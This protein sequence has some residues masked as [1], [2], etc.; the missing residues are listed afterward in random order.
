MGIFAHPSLLVFLL[1]TS[2]LAV[3]TSHPDLPPS[4]QD[5][6]DL[7]ESAE[8]SYRLQGRRLAHRGQ[9]R[10]V[11]AE[12]FLYD[13]E[14]GDWPSGPETS[15]GAGR[16]ID[17]G[18]L[19]ELLGR[20]R[21]GVVA[22][23]QGRQNWLRVQRLYQSS[24][25]GPTSRFLRIGRSGDSGGSDAVGSAGLPGLQ[26]DFNVLPHLA[27]VVKGPSVV[28]VDDADASGVHSV[29]EGER[30]AGEYGRF[31]NDDGDSS[32]GESLDTY[33]KRSGFFRFGRAFYPRS[34][35]IRIG[36]SPSVRS[37][38]NNFVRLG[39]SE[40]PRSR[41]VRIGRQSEG[42]DENA[43]DR[44]RYFNEMLRLARRSHMRIGRLPSSVFI[45]RLRMRQGDGS[46]RDDTL[47]RMRSPGFR[48]TKSGIVRA[49][50]RTSQ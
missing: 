29:P 41:M 7:L 32:A 14:D 16:H 48:M 37:S 19:R 46:G 3:M 9:L 39:R 36:K 38:S 40:T 23:G 21:N 8:K 27:S 20:I 28:S 6:L 25:R 15:Q 17:V 22:V 34:S 43:E 33:P 42:L 13:T 50:K 31:N 18:E 5:L 35:F 45:Q 49:G 10:P 30:E 47:T 44:A 26:R 12:Y 4:Q 2:I 11:T 1:M 24:K